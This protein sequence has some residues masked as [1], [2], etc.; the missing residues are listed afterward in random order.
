MKLYKQC[1]TINVVVFMKEQAEGVSFFF[2][3]LNNIT[4]IFQLEH[5]SFVPYGFCSSFI[6]F[7]SEIQL[8]ALPL[9][10]ARVAPAE[11]YSLV[12]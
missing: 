7:E 11:F 6:S 2:F 10:F 3:F 5:K 4:C 12:A 1:K 9:G 8:L